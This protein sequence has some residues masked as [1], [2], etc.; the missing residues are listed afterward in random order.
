MVNDVIVG[1]TKHSRDW[2]DVITIIVSAITLAFLVR[3]TIYAKHQRDEAKRANDLTEKALRETWISSQ[4]ALAEARASSVTAHIQA[5]T[6]NEIAYE[7]TRRSNEL[8]EKALIY[9]KR[10]WLIPDVDESSPFQEESIWKVA[11]YIS[12]TGSVPGVMIN[13]HARVGTDPEFGTAPP[14]MFSPRGAIVLPGSGKEGA[15]RVTADVP[16]DI[17]EEQ[18]LAAT[19]SNLCVYC[20]VTYKDVIS[21]ELET[22]EWETRASWIHG[23]GRRWYNNPY[24]EITLK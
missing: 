4:Q 2:F 11:F 7:S 8:A 13:A 9:G 3:Y 12:N 20:A 24:F 23:R 22:G 18:L 21:D 10:S 6:A 14:Q 15:L 19:G 5:R 16:A 1:A 17:L